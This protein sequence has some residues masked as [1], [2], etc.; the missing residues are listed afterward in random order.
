VGVQSSNIDSHQWWGEGLRAL[1]HLAGGMYPHVRLGVLT[2]CNA[3]DLSR[4]TPGHISNR[5]IGY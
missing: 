2:L 1:E 3:G 5:V 4:P